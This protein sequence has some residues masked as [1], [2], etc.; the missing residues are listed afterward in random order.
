MKQ[1]KL[2]KLES[3]GITL[4]A[5]VITIIVLLILAGVSIAMLTGENGIL[6]QAKNAK[7]ETERA[8]I[9]EQVRL[10]ILE[11]Q[12]VNGSGDITAGELEEI[13]KKYFSNGDQN[14]KDIIAG[15]STDK[16]ISKEDETI[17][18]D[19][20]EIYNGDIKDGTTPPEEDNEATVG[21]IVQPGEGNKDY[22][23]GE[24]TAKIP[25]G[26]MI[27]PG[28]EDI[29]KGLVI[30]DDPDDTEADSSS[31]VAEG[32]QFVWIP[33]AS[34][35]EYIRDISYADTNVSTTAY[36]DK[37]YLP[38]GIAPTIPEETTEP[39]DIGLINE[40]AEREAVAGKGGFYISRYEAGLE[41]TD[42]LVSKKGATVWTNKTQSEFKEI[43]KR[44]LIN[45]NSSIKSA[46][47][48]GIQWDMAMKF[49]TE[50]DENNYDVINATVSWHQGSE[51]VESGQNEED[52]AC[53]I[54]DLES[55]ATEY[56]AEKYSYYTPHQ[57]V[58]RG[59]CYNDSSPASY[60]YS[61]IGAAYS[62]ISFRFV[63]YIM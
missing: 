29:S 15:T 52:K 33:V 58:I 2:K 37:E 49:I 34:G 26:F 43:G 45:N 25:E 5:L 54:Y 51:V 30:S 9:I 50:N 56:V 28:C 44:F 27:V 13:L 3:K 46:M 8:N 39:E 21:V 10:D 31:I 53:N 12:T 38:D 36:T 6:T 32:N 63:L 11:K 57:F 22:T 24:Y 55:N 17:K 18:I 23:S 48:S 60:R 14:L 61:S 41:G 20:S 16:L 19:L 42:T 40:V 7:T 62:H 35:A 47:C 59:G 1:K 4:I